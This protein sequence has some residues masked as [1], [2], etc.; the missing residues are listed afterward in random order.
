MSIHVTNYPCLEEKFIFV[1]V[2]IMTHFIYLCISV[3]HIHFQPISQEIVLTSVP[4]KAR[5]HAESLI[6]TTPCTEE[7]SVLKD[8]TQGS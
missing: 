4:L 6:N 3:D 2:E 7:H 8:S 5:T 1:F